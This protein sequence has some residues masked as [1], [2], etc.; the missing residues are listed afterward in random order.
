MFTGASGNT[1]ADAADVAGVEPPAFVAVTTTRIV[2]P[3]SPEPSLYVEDVAPLA[4]TQLEPELLQSC[5]W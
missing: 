5:H 1:T 3:T 2:C 4:F